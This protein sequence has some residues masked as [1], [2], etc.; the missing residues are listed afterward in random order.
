MRPWPIPLLLA[1]AIAGCF[2]PSLT[3][4]QSLT[5]SEDA[6]AGGVTDSAR[7]PSPDSDTSRA[8]ANPSNPPAAPEKKGFF[9][10]WEEMAKRTEADEPNWLSPI[11]TTSG[12]LKDEIR[13]DVWRPIAPSA[14]PYYSLG[15]SKGVEFIVAPRLQLLVG[16]P[17]VVDYPNNPSR[18]GV[19]DMPFMVKFRV[20]SAPRKRGEYLCTLLLKAT[21]P[22]GSAAAGQHHPVLTPG[23]ALGKGWNNFDVQSTVG[24]YLPTSGTVLLG[25]QL[26]WDT[27]FQYRAK[28][29]LWPELEVNSVHFME[30][31]YDGETQAF[32]TPGL[33]FGR[34]RLGGPFSFSAGV[35][36]QIAVT[37]FRTYNHQ[38]MLSFRVPF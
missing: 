17:T 4:A 8:Q 26:Q 33:G 22:T 18:D 5:P 31:K 35:G 14:Q 29:K 25:R 24:G 37:Q 27:A 2:Q 3:R 15:G 38:L 9:H 19:G 32:L 6:P 7:A 30:G 23:L 13:Y 10:R 36:F 16:V 12:R 34:V 20:A 1:C 28:H 21:T 11:A